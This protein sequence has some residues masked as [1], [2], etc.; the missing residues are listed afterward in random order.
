LA[1]FAAKQIV[2]SFAGGDA[3]ATLSLSDDELRSAEKFFERLAIAMA[4]T[5]IIA[6]SLQWARGFSTFTAKPLVHAHAL[7]FMGW[8]GLFVVQARLATRGPI[9]LHRKLGWIGALWAAVLILLGC[10]ITADMVM[11]GQAPF[12]F[13]PQFF[14]IA[15]PLSV[16][17]FT[18]LTWTAIRMRKQTDWHRRLHICAMAA[19]MGPAFGRLL[20]M[21]FIGPYAYEIAVLAGLLFPLIGMVRDWR[22]DGRVHRAW[23]YGAGTVLLVLPLAHLISGSAVGDSIYASVTNGHPGASVAPHEFPPPPPMFR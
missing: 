11:R 7:A 21:P 10:W 5:I 1:S 19:I 16:L 6:F 14:L 22:E 3:V 17:C 15:N 12:F 20:P 4:V 23:L 8:T 2:G 13:R 18:A 9:T